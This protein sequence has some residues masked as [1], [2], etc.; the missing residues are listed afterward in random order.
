MGKKKTE[1]KEEFIHLGPIEIILFH[2]FNVSSC[3]VHMLE[4]G[5]LKCSWTVQ[6]ERKLQ[7]WLKLRNSQNPL[8]HILETLNKNYEKNNW[9]L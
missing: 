1:N 7:S 6:S 5:L 4:Q 8:C 9:N 2:K 3:E